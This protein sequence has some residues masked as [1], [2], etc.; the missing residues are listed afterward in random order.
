M[1]NFDK[2]FIKYRLEIIS[3]LSIEWKRKCWKK[4]NYSCKWKKKWK[5]E[6]SV[7]SWRKI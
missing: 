7:R 6:G 1:E 3:S 2:D 4:E 5:K